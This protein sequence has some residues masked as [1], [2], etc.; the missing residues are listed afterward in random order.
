MNR[1]VLA[2]CITAVIF[3]VGSPYDMHP[4]EVMWVCGALVFAVFLYG[5]Y[6][7]I[8]SL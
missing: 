7:F 2:I 8:T 1:S 5:V 4:D 6:K 3:F